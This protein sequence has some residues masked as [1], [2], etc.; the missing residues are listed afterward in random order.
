MDNSKN[1]GF[2][3]SFPDTYGLVLCG[4]R[5][6]RMC[7]DKSML[8]Y[9]DKPQRYQVYDIIQP[10]CEK[11]F[12]ACNE[13]QIKSIEA[14]YEFIQDDKSFGDIGPMN[15]LLSAFTRY[16][17]K[18]ILLIGCDYPFLTATELGL[19]SVFCKEIPAAFYNKADNVYEPMLAWY[20][21]NCF[22]TLKKMYAAKQFSL[23]RLLIESHAVKYLPTNADSIKSI[24]TKEAFTQTNNRLNA[25]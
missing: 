12:I 20:P 1:I 14:G 7:T 8:Q 2:K 4:G 9:Y 3:Y 24:D 23:Q 13:Q 17:Q 22:D 10:L 16:P 6:S 21:Y 15:A 5:S 18:N 25:G 11:V 19:F